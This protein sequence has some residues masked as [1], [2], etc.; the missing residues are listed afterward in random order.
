MGHA[1]RCTREGYALL[2]PTRMFLLGLL[3]VGE[4]K[5]HQDQERQDQVEIVQIFYLIEQEE[6]V[7]PVLTRVPQYPSGFC[8]N[9][10]LLGRPYWQDE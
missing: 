5:A 9:P 8:P 4:Q 10:A 7:E 1:F 6:V 2:L 3:R